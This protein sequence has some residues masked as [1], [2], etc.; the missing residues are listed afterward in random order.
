MSN[1]AFQFFLLQRPYPKEH[2]SGAVYKFHSGLCNE[3]YYGESIRHLDIRSGEHIGVSPLTGKKVKPSNSSS[4]CN[5]LLNCN[6]LLS[7]DNLSVL[8]HENRKCLLEIKESLR[9]T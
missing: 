3:S 4:I 6:F 8:A 7:F 5:H 1:K 9:E 2:T